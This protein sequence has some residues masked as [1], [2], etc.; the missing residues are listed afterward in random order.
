MTD[1]IVYSTAQEEAERLGV[2]ITWIYSRVRKRGV[3]MI[4]H[5]KVGKYLRFISDEVDQWLENQE[6]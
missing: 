2:P 4:P 3:E 1:R 5:R 6:K